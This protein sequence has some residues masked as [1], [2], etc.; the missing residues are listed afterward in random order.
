MT[1]HI[2]DIEDKKGQQDMGVMGWRVYEGAL[3]DGATPNQ[4]YKVTIAFFAGMFK[5]SKDDTEEEGG[6]DNDENT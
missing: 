4:A 1:D 2:R 3:N 6:D 5:G